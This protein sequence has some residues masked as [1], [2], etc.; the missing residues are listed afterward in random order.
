MTMEIAPTDALI[1]VDIQYDF[2]PGGTLP[3]K[4]GDA[5]FPVVNRLSRKF[6]LVVA[7]Q[8]WHSSDHGSFA[9]QHPGSKPL[10]VINLDGIE[11][12]LWPDHCVEGT[13]G[14]EF[15]HELDQAPFRAV[16]RKGTNRSVDSYSALMENDHWTETGLRG[17]LEGLRA[18]RLFVCGLAT[19]F[20]VRFTVLD[21]RQMG[22]EAVVISDACR[23]VDIPEGTAE[24]AFQEMKQ[25]GALILTS[26]E[27]R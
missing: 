20:C 2:C 15:H 7:T 26:D 1:V 5:V 12:V 3:L 8:D 9:S 13:R 24:S 25:A 21:A 6:P 4:L 23:G 11:Q 19:D 17:Y 22:F 14:A 27:I 10:E 18:R 16:F